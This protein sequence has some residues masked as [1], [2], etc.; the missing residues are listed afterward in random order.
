[1]PSTRTRVLDQFNAVEQELKTK[2]EEAAKEH[3][4]G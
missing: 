3:R 1:M 4:R 2:L